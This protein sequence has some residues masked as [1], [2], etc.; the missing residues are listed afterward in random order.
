VH[1]GL[2][3]TKRAG[4]LEDLTVL[5]FLKVVVLVGAEGKRNVTRLERRAVGVRTVAVRIAVGHVLQTDGE[6]VRV[7]LV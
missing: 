3:R 7:R 5:L 1:V 2:G 4:T 6:L